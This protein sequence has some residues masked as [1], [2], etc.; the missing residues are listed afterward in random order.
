MVFSSSQSERLILI[1]QTQPCRK[2]HYYKQSILKVDCHLNKMLW[3][4]R[5][6]IYLRLANFCDVVITFLAQKR[7]KC[8]YFIIH[9]YII[10]HYIICI[11]Y[12]ELKTGEL[13]TPALH[14]KVGKYGSWAT[15][16]KSFFPLPSRKTIYSLNELSAHNH[17]LST[18]KYVLIDFF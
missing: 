7:Q 10:I 13:F 18:S 4:C 3:K 1:N 16:C 14:F 9:D 17:T 2:L 11:H 5:D 12:I 6:L 15:A 8:Y